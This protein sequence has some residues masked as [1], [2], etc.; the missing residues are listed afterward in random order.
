[1][2]ERGLSIDGHLSRPLTDDLVAGAD[3]V[4]GMTREHVWRASRVADGAGAR[5]FLVGEAARLGAVVGA[6]ADGEDVR[7]WAARVAEL[8]ADG[9]IGR[10]GDEVDDP[11]GEPI[12]VYRATAARLDRDLGAVAAL[13]AP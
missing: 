1:M 12:H 13:L 4:L 10:A 5:S 6:R 11:V 8:R 9:P 3:L 2:R 7:T